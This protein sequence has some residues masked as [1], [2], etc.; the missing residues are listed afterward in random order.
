MLKDKRKLND[1]VKRIK[2][3]YVLERLCKGNLYNEN[4]ANLYYI[5]VT[6]V[7]CTRG[8]K[9]PHINLEWLTIS[10]GVLVQLVEHKDIFL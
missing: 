4:H 10:L 7:N 1:V 5:V 6:R 3:Y 8:C 2:L 9:I